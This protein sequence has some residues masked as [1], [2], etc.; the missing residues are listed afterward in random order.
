[1]HYIPEKD[2]HITISKEDLAA[3]P[4][5]IYNGDIQVIDVPEDVVP[6]VNALYKSSVIGFDTETR[7]AFKR[8]QYNSLSLIQLASESSCYLFRLNKIGFMQEIRKIL[9][10]ESML[11]I[12]LSI[13]DDFNNLRKLN[14]NFNPKGFIDLQSYVK[15]FR[16]TDNSLQRIYGILFSRRIS[17][18]QRLSNWEAP[19]LTLAQQNYAALDAKACID[20]YKCLKSGAF[21]PS[22]SPYLQYIEE[23]TEDIQK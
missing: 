15:T 17:K 20:I 3:L 4:K 11:K 6:A 13:H 16:I 2:F 8:G 14:R 18:S 9:E 21:V 5:E 10:D 1:M 23:N 19:M 12:G 22:A 7:P